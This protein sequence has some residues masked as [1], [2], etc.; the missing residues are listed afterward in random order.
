MYEHAYHIDFGANAAAYVD[1]FMANIAW[2][3]IA[4]RFGG[5]APRGQAT[6]RRHADRAADARRRSRPAW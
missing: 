1:A 2:Q 6:H 4:A 5:V 3:R